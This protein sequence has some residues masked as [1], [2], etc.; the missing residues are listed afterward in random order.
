MYG[1]AVENVYHLVLEYDFIRL[2]LSLT[3]HVT[4]IKLS[5]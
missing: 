1:L 4:N 3:D 2:N 5:G